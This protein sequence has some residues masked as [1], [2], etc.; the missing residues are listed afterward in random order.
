MALH[1]YTFC[2][3][4]YHKRSYLIYSYPKSFEIGAA[5]SERRSCGGIGVSHSLPTYGNLVGKFRFNE[6][7]LGDNCILCQDV[8]KIWLKIPFLASIYPIEKGSPNFLDFGAESPIQHSCWG[9]MQGRNKRFSLCGLQDLARYFDR[10][11]M[12][13]SLR[14]FLIIMFPNYI[15]WPERS[16]FALLC[17]DTNHRMFC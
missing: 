8:V 12:K 1:F 11:P 17:D 14:A 16:T 6:L 9:Q 4:R 2:L 5:A 15:V 3:V 13:I 10:C 7:S